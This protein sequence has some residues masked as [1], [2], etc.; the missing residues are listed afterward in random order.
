MAEQGLTKSRIDAA[1]PAILKGQPVVRFLFDRKVIGFG[2]KVSPGGTKTYFVQY[3]QGSGRAA[4]KRRYTI[5]KHGSPWTVDT[6]RQ[7]A[8]RILGRVAGGANPADERKLDP[9]Q[10]ISQ[11]A[12]RFLEIHVAKKK[13]RTEQTYRALISRLILPELGAVRIPDL[14]A[15]HVGNLHHKLRQIR[16]T[17]NRTVALLSK[18]LA[19]GHRN[20]FPLPGDNPCRGL[21][22]YAERSRERFLK[23]GESTRLGEALASADADPANLY[24]VAAVRLLIF[25]GARMTEILTLRWDWIDLDNGVVRLPDSKTGA[26]TIYLS[27]PARAVLDALP[28][29]TDNPYVIVGAKDGA[30]LINL[31]K[32]WRRIRNAAGLPDVRLHDLRHSFASVGAGAGMGLPMIGRL[33]GHSQPQTT[34]RYAHLDHDPIKAANETIGRRIAAAMAGKPGAS[35]VRLNRSKRTRS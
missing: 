18:M 14:T 8:L 35:V 13:A 29:M 3:R 25:T 30:H 31:E 5:G 4:P 21:E 26:K 27:A 6:A 32:P 2:L 17:A 9:T 23:P 20:G 12:E 7:E 10:T 22:K 11:L 15:G 16:V 28:R 19:W 24:Q 1:R 33:L 34:A